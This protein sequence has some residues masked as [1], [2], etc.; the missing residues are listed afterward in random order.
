[1]IRR[2]YWQFYGTPVRWRAVLRSVNCRNA[3]QVLGRIGEK[4]F[5]RPP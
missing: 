5:G 4:F 2:A 1:M 3:R